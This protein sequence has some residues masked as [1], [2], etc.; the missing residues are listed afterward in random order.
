M[1][2]VDI[3]PVDA[4]AIAGRLRVQHDTVH[5]WHYRE[6]SS[7]PPPRWKLGG[8]PVW[9][10]TEVLEWAG[11]TGRL[12]TQELE[13]QYEEMTGLEPEGS[14][15]PGRPT[16]DARKRLERLNGNAG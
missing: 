8:A 2:T 5:R 13:R 15:R 4:A 14:R 6:S 9:E 10:W 7:F 3:E 12:P 11:R 16:K 1:A